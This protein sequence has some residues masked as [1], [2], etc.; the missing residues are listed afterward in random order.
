[1]T[2]VVIDSSS[3]G[4]QSECVGGRFYEITKAEVKQVEAELLNMDRPW[5]ARPG[6]GEGLA[7]PI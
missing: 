6:P 3:L 5:S 2:T 7:R 1:M 4:F